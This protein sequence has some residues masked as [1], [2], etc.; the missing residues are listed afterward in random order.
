M[1]KKYQINFIYRHTKMYVQAEHRKIDYFH[2]SF[3]VLSPQ[4]EA[5]EYLPLPKNSLVNSQ[6]IRGSYR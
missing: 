4:K 5:A 1:S 2:T 6:R 3:A